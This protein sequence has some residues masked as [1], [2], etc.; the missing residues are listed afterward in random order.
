MEHIKANLPPT[1][2]LYK[3]GGGEGVFILVDAETKKAYDNDESGTMYEGII[4]NDSW[5][6]PGLTHGAKI[7]IEMRGTMRPVVPFNWLAEHYG[8]PPERVWRIA[9]DE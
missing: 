7:P 2:E 6:Y 9:D 8:T 5:Y 4:D 1:E 3:Q